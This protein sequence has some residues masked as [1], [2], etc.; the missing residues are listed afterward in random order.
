MPKHVPRYMEPSRYGIQKQ[1]LT[2]MVRAK[3]YAFREGRAFLRGCYTLFRVPFDVGW[4]WEEHRVSKKPANSKPPVGHS[5]PRDDAPAHRSPLATRD[6]KSYNS[7]EL[8]RKSL[9]Q[10][11]A[12]HLHQLLVLWGL[13]WNSLFNPRLYSSTRRDV[14]A[15][16]GLAS[17]TQLCATSER[18]DP[19]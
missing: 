17:P 9:R 8:K 7:L 1:D 16:C 5:V 2:N 11:L 3:G 15:R 4:P 6:N 14:D 12:R 10:E 19:P 13:I 18:H